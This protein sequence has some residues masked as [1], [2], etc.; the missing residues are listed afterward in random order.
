MLD[1]VRG[2]NL[3]NVDSPLK[4]QSILGDM[5]GYGMRA[6]VRKVETNPSGQFIRLELAASVPAYRTAIGA[7]PVEPVPFAQMILDDRILHTDISE[8]FH[9]NG[10]PGRFDGQILTF[11]TGKAQG[12]STRIIEHQVTG[13]SV[14]GFIH[15]LIVL[16]VSS[17]AT[18]TPITLP[19]Q[20]RSLELAN[21]N[22]RFTNPDAV[23]INNRA[24]SGTCLLYTS[25][26]ADE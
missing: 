5:Y 15:A 21:G 13:N 2:V 19:E 22:A 3:D 4:G 25:D 20:I 6:V 24:F 9:L 1:L 12:M 14:D 23:I 7:N 16:P 26:A 8:P 11:V 18:L 10:T 17:D